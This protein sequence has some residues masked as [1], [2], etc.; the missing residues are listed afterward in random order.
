MEKV[1]ERRRF[2]VIL[3]LLAVCNTGGVFPLR[4]RKEGKAGKKARKWRIMDLHYYLLFVSG[5]W[6]ERGSFFSVYYS[7]KD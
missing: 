4:D 5:V 7:T 6:M 1:A 3:V 2:R